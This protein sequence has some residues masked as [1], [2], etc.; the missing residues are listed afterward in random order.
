MYVEDPVQEQDICVYADLKINSLN[1]YHA[2]CK[3]I[4]L[5]FYLRR[6]TKIEYE[7]LKG[8]LDVNS[9]PGRKS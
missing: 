9:R 4:G 5:P 3:C 6:T 8:H 1:Y 2:N 7:S